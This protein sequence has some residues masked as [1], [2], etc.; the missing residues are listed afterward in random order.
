ML[1]LNGWILFAFIP[2][3]LIYKKH[4]KDKLQKQ[5]KLLYLSLIFMFLAIS[6]P[7]LNN[8]FE[9][10][11]L[12]SQEFIVALDA[13]YSMQAD[14]L[15][16]SR[17][18][19]AKKAIKKLFLLHPKDK[20]TLFVFTSNTLL[21]SPPTTDTQISLTALD[22]LNPLY[23]LTKSTDILELFK[24][25]SKLPIKD[26]KLIIFS[27]GGD[28]HDISNILDIS[29][30]N[31]ITPYIVA[32]ATK[33]GATLKKGN[34]YLKKRNNGLVISK[35]N[36]ILKELSANT[37]GKYYTLSSLD[38]IN[39]LSDDLKNNSK[40]K[41]QMKI[42]SYKELFIIPLSISILLFFLSITKFSETIFLLFILFFI[43][44]KVDAKILD[45][46]HIKLA[47]EL[48]KNKHYDEA[49]KEYLK[50]KP[51]VSSYYNIATAYYKAKKYKSALYYY[52]QIKSKNSDIKQ[53][54]FYNMANSSLKLKKYTQA[55]ELYIKSLA[56]KEDKDAL[57]NLHLLQRLK[58]KTT[59]Q[60]TQHPQKK[61][62]SKQQ[63]KDKKNQNSTS[64]QSSSQST[65]G[66]GGKKKKNNSS[67]SKT[68][69]QKNRY[70]MSYKAYEKI[71]K[72][73]I[74][75]KEPW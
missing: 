49:A 53:K 6:R 12:D 33:K 47:K 21:I 55:K 23:I 34:T 18:I 24:T 54:I 3:F 71:N 25:V 13:S 39:K 46:Y 15:K 30:K 41:E 17:Y 27:D 48:Y 44:Q 22:A 1:L 65:N 72:G 16:P 28:K 63:T 58:I 37:N 69:T 60:N 51:S 70:Q 26:K 7:A 50:V 4:K 59:T 42:K 29:Q 31:N 62:I 66:G 68:T 36:P 11:K 75:E 2:L 56:I 10:Q 52:A 57:Y 32:T 73:Y 43:P 64:N 45:F 5:T 9:N 19:M 8:T 14:D 20:F 67:I 61:G 35:I 38:V 74:D 40:T